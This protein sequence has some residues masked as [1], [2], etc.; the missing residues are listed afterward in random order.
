MARWTTEQD[1]ELLA[2]WE[3]GEPWSLIAPALGRQE[4]ACQ[5]HLRRLQAVM[6]LTDRLIQDNHRLERRRFSRRRENWLRRWHHEGL[7]AEHIARQ[8]GCT[9]AEVCERLAVL[10]A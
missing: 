4:P 2:R 5:E 1:Y 7:S 9:A 8:L 6:T 10:E 3:R